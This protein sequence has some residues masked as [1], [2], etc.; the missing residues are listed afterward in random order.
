MSQKRIALI[1]DSTCDI[2]AALLAQ[3]G[4]Y[5]QAHIVIWGE[6]QYRDRLEIQPEEFYRRLGAD[7]VMPTTSQA[8]VAD[9]SMMYQKACDDGAEEI[10]VIS[11]S[12]Q[13][14]G[15]YQSAMGAVEFA[16]V[17]VRVF[18]SRMVTMGLGWQVLAA[19]RARESG[20]DAAD[21]LAAAD[22]V[23]RRVQLYIC[24]DTLEYV[25]RGGRIGNASRFVGTLLN[26]KPL[27]TVDHDS[28]IVEPVSM[29]MTRR[30]SVDML[31]SKFFSLLDTRQKMRI[32]VLHGDA[33]KEASSLAERVRRDYNPVEL[34]TDITG[35]ALGIHTGPQALALCGYSE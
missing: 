12:S 30:K 13:L 31:Y 9:F 17:P 1:T 10:V 29:A 14:S 8:T 35:P 3:Y 33:S 4:I 11:V 27:I 24:L 18:D 34:F 2:P 7:A 28:G 5:V 19:A 16:R 20:G 25:Y 21:M 26:I 15:A 22:R 6:H 32:A 23:R